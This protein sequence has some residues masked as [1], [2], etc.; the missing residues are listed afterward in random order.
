VQDVSGVY[1]APAGTARVSFGIPVDAA[2]GT[3]QIEADDLTSG[4]RLRT[5]FTVK[6]RTVKP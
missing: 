6:A 3:W 1:P 5:S 4:L 2:P